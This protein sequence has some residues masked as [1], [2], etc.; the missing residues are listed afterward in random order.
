MDSFFRSA[1]VMEQVINSDKAALRDDGQSASR[2]RKGAALGE[3]EREQV[4]ATSTATCSSSVL[5]QVVAD[6]WV[7][8]A[9]ETLSTS[10]VLHIVRHGEELLLLVPCTNLHKLEGIAVGKVEWAAYPGLASRSNATNNGN[11]TTG[12]TASSKAPAVLPWLQPPFSSTGNSSTS[13]TAESGA[14]GGV[15]PFIS[16]NIFGGNKKALTP[17]SAIA[18]TSTFISTG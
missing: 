10:I 4:Q 11:G 3:Q 14:A 12:G 16:S 9:G 5:Y 1:Q 8:S 18:G 17:T 15:V 7:S 6:A 13:G 2:A